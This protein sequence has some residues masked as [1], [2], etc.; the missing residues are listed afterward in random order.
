MRIELPKC[1]ATDL[2]FLKAYQLFINL[3]LRSD[4][5]LSIINVIFVKSCISVANE[6][7]KS[8]IEL[9]LLSMIERHLEFLNETLHVRLQYLLASHIGFNVTEEAF[10]VFIINDFLLHFRVVFE[11]D[12]LA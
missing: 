2:Y 1:N 11:R 7:L 3:N 6:T 8:V 5:L 10:S 4:P 9:N 12:E